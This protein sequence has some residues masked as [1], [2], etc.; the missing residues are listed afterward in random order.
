MKRFFV[1]ALALLLL[2]C[3]CGNADPSDDLSAVT[4]RGVLRVGV[5][6]YEPL[7]YLSGGVWTGYDVDLARAFAAD[8]GVEAEFTV[9]DWDQRAVLLADGSIDC[10][11]SGV[12]LT[13]TGSNGLAA[14][15]VYLE[16]P[17]V[18]VLSGAVS[19]DAFR[20]LTFAV[21]TGTVGQTVA[22]ENGYNVTAVDSADEIFRRVAEGECDGGITDLIVACTHVAAGSPYDRLSVGEPLNSE[23]YVALFRPGSSLVPAVNGFLLRIRR[24]GTMASIAERYNLTATI[25]EE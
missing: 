20:Y 23:G 12:S 16:N 22:V 4:E 19:P 9:I 7:S 17:Q 24:D 13:E 25:P 10:V 11:W 21:E 2:V 8:V 14:S 6:F 1:L 3:G 18:P 15:D 5:S